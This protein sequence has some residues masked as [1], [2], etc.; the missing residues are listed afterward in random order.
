MVKDLG[1]AW[2]KEAFRQRDVLPLYGSSELI[3]KAPNKASRLFAQ[4]PSGF[5][6]S[7]VGRASCTSLILLEKLAASGDDARGRKVIISV[8]PS[9]FIAKGANHDG[10]GGNFSTMQA[11]ELAFS[12]PLS[13]QLKH[14]IAGRMLRYPEVFDKSPVLAV[15]MRALA[16]DRLRDRLLYFAAV[17]LGRLQNAVFHLQ[18]HFEVIAHLK[19][20]RRLRHVPK[21]VAK[22]LDWD[23]L[24]AS[25]QQML[26]PLPPD[27]PD[28]RLRQFDSDGLFLQALQRSYEWGDFELLLRT[29][30]ELGLDPLVVS[31][32]L[33][34]AHFE[35]MGLSPQAIDAY[36]WR[37]REFSKR[38]Q[39]PVVDFA[40]LGEDPQ[41]FADHFC[42]PSAKGWIYMD[43]ALDDFYHGRPS[44]ERAGPSDPEET[45]SNPPTDRPRLPRS[46]PWSGTPGT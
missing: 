25:S 16:G 40:D 28:A 10:F 19:A 8:S 26:K 14:S 24:M 45:S 6:V 18:D 27:V 13:L 4:Y 17:P 22:T 3:K 42:H 43:R 20:E 32:P 36:A 23:A 35:R 11:S 39:V 38:Y 2:Q 5:A 9:W 1:I 15:A 37:L 31:M 21:R 29:A 30:R 7:P 33:E 44:R 41:F 34:Y 46:G 12:A